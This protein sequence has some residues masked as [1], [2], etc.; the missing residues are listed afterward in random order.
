MRIAMSTDNNTAREVARTHFRATVLSAILGCVSVVLAAWIGATVGRNQGRAEVKQELTQQ[1]SQLAQRDK[2]I[3]RLQGEVKSLREQLESASPDKSV[4][5]VTTDDTWRDPQQGEDFTFSLRS[6]SRRGTTVNCAFTAVADKRDYRL[7]VWGTS[8]IIDGD[9]KEWLASAVSLA[10][11]NERVDRY[12]SIA[13]DLVR[14]VPINGVI[15][16]ELI[17]VEQR[18]APVVEIVT[19]DGNR[20]FRN[21][22]I[23]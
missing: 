19:S 13:K 7:L 15:A 8:R 11:N 3:V 1:D 23:S 2:E 14:G 16:F 18:V 5:D 20:Q 22:P 10:G 21:V 6:C 17:P 9:G 12:T 4:S